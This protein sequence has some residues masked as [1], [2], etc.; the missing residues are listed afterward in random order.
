MPE[1]NNYTYTHTELATILIKERE[2]H[3][4][5]WGLYVEFAFAGAN[6]GGTAPNDSKSVMPAAISFVNK[7]GIQKF[8]SPNN[9]TVDAAVVNPSVKKAGKQSG[10][11][12]IA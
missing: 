9:L 4:G 5:L 1:I 8:D 7:I 3:E 11:K 6:V 2:I 12:T 10:P